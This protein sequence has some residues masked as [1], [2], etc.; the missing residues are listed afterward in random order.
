MATESSEEA[1]STAMSTAIN[2]QEL[3]AFKPNDSGSEVQP[4]T[5][6]HMPS[7]HVSAESPSSSSASHV[8]LALGQIDQRRSSQP[9]DNP[10]QQSW[11]SLAGLQPMPH[12]P[13]DEESAQSLPSALEA[14]L[15]QGVEATLIEENIEHNRETVYDATRIP[16]PNPESE[17]TWWQR[18]RKYVF[19]ALVSV[20]FGIMAGI[21][22]LLMSFGNG[23]D[24]IGGDQQAAGELPSQSPFMPLSSTRP[25]P[26]RPR[27]PTDRPSEHHSVSQ[28]STLEPIL[29][30]MTNS[31]IF[32]PSIAPSSQTVLSGVCD[33]AR[34]QTKFISSFEFIYNDKGMGANTDFSVWR[35]ELSSNDGWYMLGDV[36]LPRYIPAPE[37]GLLVKAAGDALAPPL[38]YNFIW[39]DTGSGGLMDVSFWEPIPDVGY[40][41]L[42]HV[43]QPNYRKPSTDLIRCIKTTYLT[44]AK[45]NLLWSDAGS[46]ADFDVSV[47]QVESWYPCKAGPQPNT[48]ITSN[49]R[50]APD[51][52]H[53][54]ALNSRCVVDE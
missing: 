24:T 1:N 35:P 37:K 38:D 36:G 34:I 22:G 28:L 15:V 12:P 17:R 50:E 53:F 43:V 51:D 26:E 9:V 2:R 21:I 25:T 40:A 47:Y 19:V 52:Y 11:A 48:F 32:S 16:D 4:T 45:K 33:G 23:N 6:S 42:G 54:K 3:G 14:T 7:Q 39:R 20:V 44:S 30:N 8:T 13:N 49:T 41:C 31:P 10:G 29:T 5:R 27:Q 46:G 18:N